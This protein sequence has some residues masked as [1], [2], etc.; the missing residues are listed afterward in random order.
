LVFA[1]LIYLTYSNLINLSQ[2]WV[3]SG[4]LPFGLAWWPFHLLAFLGAPA[5][6]I[7]AVGGMLFAGRVIHAL[8][9]LFQEGPSLGRSVGM[10]LTWL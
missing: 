5:M 6:L 9:L 3:R 2:A 1:V 8:G 4:S 7:H 10:I